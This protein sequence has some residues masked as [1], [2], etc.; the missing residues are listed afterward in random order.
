M[1]EKPI[2]KEKIEQVERIKENIKGA[3]SIFFVDFR[4][5]NVPEDTELRKRFRK[6]N[7]NYFVCKNTLLKRALADLHVEELYPILEG[8]TAFAVSKE[9]EIM[10]GKII[11]DFVKKLPEEKDVL[12]FKAGIIANAFMDAKD[13]YQIVK[14]PPRDVLL[15]QVL[16]G[17]TSPISGLV[18]TLNST[19]QK[20]VIAINEIKNRKEKA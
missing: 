4:G 3:K 15:S 10:P 2:K 5:L 6:N 8:P 9:D 16:S 20:L 18:F 12:K 11:D 1:R 13:L 7:V 14:L 17:L 19:L